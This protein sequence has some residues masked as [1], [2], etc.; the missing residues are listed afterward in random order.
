MKP[1]KQLLNLTSF[2]S[3]RSGQLAGSDIKNR[4]ENCSRFNSFLSNG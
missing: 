3:T 1:L 4:T 2:I